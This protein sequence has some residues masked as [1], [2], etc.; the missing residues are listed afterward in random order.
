MKAVNINVK[1]VNNGYV[2]AVDFDKY[3][4]DQVVL[5]HKNRDEIDAH[6]HE[7]LNKLEEEEIEQPY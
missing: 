2:V 7:V 4:K 3:Q 6:L 1:K 5:V